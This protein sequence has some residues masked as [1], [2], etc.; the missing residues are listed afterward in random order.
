MERVVEDGSP[1]LKLDWKQKMRL[2]GQIKT[3]KEQQA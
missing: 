3:L 2:K 1:D